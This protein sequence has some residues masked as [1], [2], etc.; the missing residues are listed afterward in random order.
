MLILGVILPVS[1]GQGDSLIQRTVHLWMKIAFCMILIFRLNH[2]GIDNRDI[3]RVKST[4]YYQK[5]IFLHI[6]SWL[7]RL[8]TYWTYYNNVP[9]CLIPNLGGIWNGIFNQIAEFNLPWL[10]HS[11]SWDVWFS[12]IHS[13]IQVQCIEDIHFSLNSILNLMIF[14]I[15]SVIFLKRHRLFQPIMYGTLSQ[16]LWSF[17]MLLYVVYGFNFNCHHHDG[18]LR[19]GTH[20]LSYT[21]NNQLVRIWLRTYVNISLWAMCAN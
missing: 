3:S 7:Y 20:E 9:Q 17:F 13:S 21:L 11:K 6:H 12:M 2:Y 5:H 15:M 16:Y 1:S 4:I 8:S 19:Y 14:I 18:T 10:V